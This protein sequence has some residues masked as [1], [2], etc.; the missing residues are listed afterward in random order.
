MPDSPLTGLLAVLGAGVLQGS[1]MLP[2]EA[3]IE[4]YIDR[5]KFVL[6]RMD[7]AHA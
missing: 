5:L 6:A 2:N 3:D 4:R 7:G 1:F